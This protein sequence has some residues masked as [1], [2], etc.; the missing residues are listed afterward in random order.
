MISTAEDSWAI[1]VVIPALDEEASI[2]KVIEALWHHQ[3]RSVG[4][5]QTTYASFE[6]MAFTI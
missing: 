4:L 5:T 1:R 3:I 2:G 6:V